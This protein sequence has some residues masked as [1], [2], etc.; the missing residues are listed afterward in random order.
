MKYMLLIHH[1]ST[2][3]P[4]NEAWDALPDSEKGAIFAASRRSERRRE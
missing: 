2:P 4:G 1:G 3:V